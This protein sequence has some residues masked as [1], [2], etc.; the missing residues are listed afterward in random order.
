ME[1]DRIVKMRLGNN[2]VEELEK[3][4]LAE[5]TLLNVNNGDCICSNANSCILYEDA[6]NDIEN[7]F[8]SVPNFMKFF[9]KEVLIRDLP[10]WKMV[11]DLDM[12]RAS[13][14]LSTD[15]ILEEM[16]Q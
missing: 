3:N 10:L 13:Y 14:L 7:I 8:G 2:L 16:L 6:L 4:G 9:Q 5:N 1:Y 15:R 11:G 12:E